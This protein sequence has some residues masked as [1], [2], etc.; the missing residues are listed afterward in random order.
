VFIK[1]KQTLMGSAAGKVLDVPDSEGQ[2]LIDKGIAETAGDALSPV[3]SKAMESMTEKLNV[4][5]IKR[6]SL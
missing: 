4:L 1:L 2:S 5:T 6:A 3:I